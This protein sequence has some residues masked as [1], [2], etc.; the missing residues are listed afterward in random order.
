[1]VAKT[2]AEFINQICSFFERKHPSELTMEQWYPEV[3]F[4]PAE[5]L[6]WIADKI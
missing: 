2:F 1:M 4:I 6:T 5:S 3:E